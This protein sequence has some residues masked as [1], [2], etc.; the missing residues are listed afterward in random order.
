MKKH[1]QVD[2]D[3]GKLCDLMSA[4]NGF[5]DAAQLRWD[6]LAKL[7]PD[8]FLYKGAWTTS[9]AFKNTS[10]VQIDTAIEDIQI[11]HALGM[12]VGICVELI[13]D[14]GYPDHI[15]ALVDAPVDLNAWRIADPD[16]GRDILLKDRYGDVR[17]AIKGY[18]LLVGP[19][20]DFPSLEAVPEVVQAKIIRNAGI[21]AWKA[22]Q[23]YQGK[24]VAT[25]AKE[26]LDTLVQS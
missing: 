18:R 7:F 23:V 24:H 14:E 21:A 10:L 22:A 13:G 5:D 6:V 17:R 3:P 4:N 12:A 9:A 19:A 16:G 26:I 2:I 20:T 25:Y 1:F 15:V 11:A 8:V